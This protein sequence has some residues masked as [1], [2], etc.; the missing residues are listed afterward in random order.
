MKILINDFA[1][2]LIDFI[3]DDPQEFIGGIL[4]WSGLFVIGF[5]MFVIG[6]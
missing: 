4:A 3:K 2:E 5:M 6:G 1:H